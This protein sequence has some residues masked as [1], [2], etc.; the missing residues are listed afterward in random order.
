M[1]DFKSKSFKKHIHVKE[2][3]E[4]KIKCC[5]SDL[6][7]LNWE[8]LNDNDLIEVS[9]IV[10]RTDSTEDIKHESRFIE[11]KDLCYAVKVK[12]MIDGAI[13]F[14]GED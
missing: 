2:A 9:H 6:T 10:S 3:N 13:T 11:F 7:K 1:I 5:A 4:N 8:E 14:Q 12:L